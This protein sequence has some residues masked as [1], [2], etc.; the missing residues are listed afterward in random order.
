MLSYMRARVSNTLA[1]SAKDWVDTFGKY[2]SGTYI[3]Q[4]MVLDMQLY[5]IH[6]KEI[7]PEF[8]YVLEETPGYIRYED[9]TDV[10]KNQTYWASFNNPYFEDVALITGQRSLCHYDSSECYA[11]DPRGLLFAQYQSTLTSIEDVKKLILHNDFQHDPVSQNDSC[12]VSAYVIYFAL[13][14]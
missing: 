14:C 6:S 4:W 7:L 10:L 1:H 12:H 8:F 9:M 3:N 5:N 13:Y 11:S 2:H